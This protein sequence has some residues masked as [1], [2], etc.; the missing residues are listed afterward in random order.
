MLFV[1]AIIGIT[2]VIVALLFVLTLWLGTT[3]LFDMVRD[4]KE[5]PYKAESESQERS[6]KNDI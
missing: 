5:C 2:V 3:G 6:D 1:F 4:E